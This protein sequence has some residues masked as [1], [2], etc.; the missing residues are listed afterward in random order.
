MNLTLKV[1]AAKT[2]REGP[3]TQFSVHNMKT[4]QHSREKQNKKT[5]GRKFYQSPEKGNN[6]LLSPKV[7]QS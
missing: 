5:N 1:L 4:Y 7:Q 2:N 3:S 6:D